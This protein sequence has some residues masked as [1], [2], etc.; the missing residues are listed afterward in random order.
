MTH[1]TTLPARQQPLPDETDVLHSALQ[2]ALPAPDLPASFRTR[3]LARVQSEQLADMAA[4]RRQ[5][6]LDYQRERQQLQADYRQLRRDR[7]ALIVAG[8]FSAGVCVSLL[9]PWL[10]AL[11]GGETSVSAGLVAL[12]MVLALGFAAWIERFGKPELPG[13]GGH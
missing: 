3:L 2:Q 8:A 11:L 10:Y 1:E 6:D 12:V 9:L 5:L 7:L 4:R 13:L